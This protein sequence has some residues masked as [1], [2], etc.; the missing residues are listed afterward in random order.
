[1][2]ACFDVFCATGKLQ[3][4]YKSFVPKS[5]DLH[6]MDKDHGPNFRNIFK[7]FRSVSYKFVVDISQ[8]FP[9]I[10]KNNFFISFL[11]IFFVK[12]L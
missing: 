8:V 11:K 6:D 10:F 12:C 2:K 7:I 9:S 3:C 5:K 4:C 1:V